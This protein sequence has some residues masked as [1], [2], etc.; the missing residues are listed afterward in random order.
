MWLS[1]ILLT[2]LSF[3]GSS[4][5][6]YPPAVSNIVKQ[7]QSLPKTEFIQFVLFSHQICT[8][9]TP[10]HLS[11]TYMTFDA[12]LTLMPTS[13][14]IF[15]KWP[16]V[17]TKTLSGL[18]VL[19]ACMAYYLCHS[20]QLPIGPLGLVVLCLFNKMVSSL[21]LMILIHDFFTSAR[22]QNSEFCT[23]Q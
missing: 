14:C 10:F 23:W 6:I 20:L 17:P 13:D 1:N 3:M 4:E 22:V 12:Y 9:F 7:L 18:H 2:Q 5:A 21:K 8:P 19:C 15:S 16:N 11:K